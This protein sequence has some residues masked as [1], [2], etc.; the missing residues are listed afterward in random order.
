[1]SELSISG[2]VQNNG[3]EGIGITASNSDMDSGEEEDA[4]PSSHHMSNSKYEELD[5]ENDAGGLTTEKGN[6]IHLQSREDAEPP[7]KRPRRDHT[8]DVNGKIEFEI[9]DEIEADEEDHGNGDD[10]DDDELSDDEIYAW[11]EEGVDKN[12]QAEK[13]DSI[14]V[15][16]EK[17]VLKEKG[18]DPFDILPE[19]WVVVTHNSG[20]PVYLHKES[21]VCTLARPYFLGPG[22]VRK[23]DIPLSAIPCLQYKREI[24]KEATNDANSNSDEPE[25]T[26]LKENN[27]LDTND[28]KPNVLEAGNTISCVEPTTPQPSR[29][30]A[31][32]METNSSGQETSSALA[33]GSVRNISKTGA[34]Q[35]ADT[36]RTPTKE[37]DSEKSSSMLVT[38]AISDSVKLTV[39]CKNQLVTSQS[40]TCLF[41]QV[42]SSGNG[43]AD[44]IEMEDDENI[45]CATAS[46]TPA[47]VSV[48]PGSLNV[49][50]TQ[51]GA[52][53]EENGMSASNISGGKDLGNG[54]VDGTAQGDQ[55]LEVHPVKVESAEERRK[56]ASLD[57]P[58]VREYCSRLFEFRTITVRKYKT[59]RDRRRHMTQMKKQ[60]RPELP[61]NTKLIT[62]SLNVQ[63]KP[64]DFKSTKRKEFLLNP[65]GKSYVCILHE[66]VQHTMRVQ[67]R[68]IFKE[69]ESALTPYSA[70]VVI[71]DVEYGVGYASSK[72]AAKLEAAKDTLNILIPEMNKV[73]DDQKGEGEDLSFF[74]EIKIEDPRIY[75]LGN[76]AGQPSPYQI[77]C[78][79][80]RR[81][82]GLGETHCEMEMKQLKHQKSEFTM[83]VGKHTAT[84]IAKN[85]RDGKQRAAQAILQKLHSHV[86]SWGS[87][88]RLYGKC[89]EKYFAE[90]KDE[91]NINELQAQV[92]ANRPNNAILDKLKE[93]MTRLHTQRGAI[94]SKGKLR[95]ETTE[96]PAK[97]PSLDL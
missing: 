88:L 45:P 9:I 80:L 95:V 23:H 78:E 31:G 26:K 10:S 71:N 42:Q 97:V 49:K 90:K 14:P 2:T 48:D 6:K 18:H 5:C 82:Y 87:L 63:L 24:E 16:R 27:V 53:L 11:L 55:R 84:V 41:K 35:D 28:V 50:V 77:L 91:M 62:C 22:S 25:Q 7:R 54:A 73:T 36:D 12:V 19:G 43:D 30:T 65:S 3:D 83:T 38:N 40:E 69:M 76:K 68:Y 46:A 64:G 17:V 34:S 60:S 20:M 33:F 74:D 51:K 85:K 8:K 47:K 67:P 70:T 58:A 21:R 92:K 72:K 79:C 1:M 56:Q 96:L 44:D 81:N 93:E 13:D 61:P 52:S 37:P 59:W 15:E 57:P 86:T 89:S 29:R 39:G 94:Q 75:E 4:T 32:I 66:Y